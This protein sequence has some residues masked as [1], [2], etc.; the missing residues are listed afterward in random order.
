MTEKQRNFVKS[1]AATGSLTKAALATYDITN[2]KHAGQIGFN[3]MKGLQE[4]FP[5]VMER[6]GLTD[7]RIASTIEKALD[8]EVTFYSKA[9]GDTITAPDWQSRLQAASIAAKLKGKVPSA[10]QEVDHNHTF[11]ITRGEVPL[12]SPTPI[13]VESVEAS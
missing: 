1:Y 5:D 8:A 7:E 4:T 12:V 13:V 10:K 11:V 2:P 9:K 3:I 6:V